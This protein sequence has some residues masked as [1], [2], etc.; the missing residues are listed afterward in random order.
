MYFIDIR[1]G[2]DPFERR[3]TN[4]SKLSPQIQEEPDFLDVPIHKEDTR[5]LKS[6]QNSPSTP[7]KIEKEHM[8]SMFKNFRKGKFLLLISKIQFRGCLAKV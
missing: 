8:F 5:S 6:T 2:S 1:P 7:K 4:P 3:A